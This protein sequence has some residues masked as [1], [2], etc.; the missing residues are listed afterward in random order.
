MQADKELIPHLFRTEYSKITS[1]L[2]KLFGFDHI[3]IAED[4]ASETFLL[5]A[6][7]WGMKGIPDNPVAWLYAVA[8]NR[9]KD[10]L[11]RNAIFSEKVKAEIQ[12]ANTELYEI[13]IDLSNKNISDSLLQMMFAI[14]N[15]SISTEAQIGLSLR[16]LCGFGI[17]EIA[18]AF[19]SN[20]ETINKR[21]FRAKEKLRNEKVKIEFPSPSEI[22]KR[23]ETVMTTIYLLFN[24]GYYS[25]SQN[26]T[27]RKD[28]C[29]EAMRLCNMLVENNSTNKP[30]VNALLSLMC[31]HAS[32]FEARFNKSG[33]PVLYGEQDISL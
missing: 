19:L 9:A 30:S 32:R 22:N 12:A 2:G 17:E 7:T 5:A 20:K 27:L 28:L 16:I 31:F 11:K 23:L 18:D 25:V 24:E 33:D 13:E 14:C 26:K 29:L 21:L 6:E 10:Y 15:P 8:K 4:I 3:E 1:V